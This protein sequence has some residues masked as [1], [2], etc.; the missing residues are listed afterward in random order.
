MGKN[1]K[2]IDFSKEEAK[3]LYKIIKEY[4]KKRSRK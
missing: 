3:A 1:E 2:A 4:G